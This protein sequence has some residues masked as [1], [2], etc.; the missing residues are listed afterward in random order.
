MHAVRLRMVTDRE[1]MIRHAVAWGITADEV[2]EMQR[3]IAIMRR[4]GRY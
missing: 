2:A 3:E 4:T 1:I